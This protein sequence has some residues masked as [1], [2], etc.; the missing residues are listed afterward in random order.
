MAR[1][2]EKDR[3]ES[4]SA[5]LVGVD[6]LIVVLGM[7]GTITGSTPEMGGENFTTE[8]RRARRRDWVGK[9]G[10]GRG[11]GWGEENSREGILK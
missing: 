11:E 2:T 9:M 7:I 10:R 6:S 5:G 4:R 8:L 3:T 1:F